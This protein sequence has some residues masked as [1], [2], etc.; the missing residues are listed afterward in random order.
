MK[1]VSRLRIVKGISFLTA[2]TFIGMPLLSYGKS[3]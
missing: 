2:L 1:Q 3:N